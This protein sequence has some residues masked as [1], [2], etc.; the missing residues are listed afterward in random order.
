MS[1]SIAGEWGARRSRQR[2]NQSDALHD[3][4][5][6]GRGDARQSMRCD[7]S[8]SRGKEWRVGRGKKKAE[9]KKK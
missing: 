1:R 9:P 4:A 2:R 6:V 8:C 7:S 3:K 5:E